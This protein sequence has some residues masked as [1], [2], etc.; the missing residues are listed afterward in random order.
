[1]THNGTLYLRNVLFSNV[2]TNLNYTGTGSVYLQNCTF[3]TSIY[4]MTIVTGSQGFTLLATNC[5]LANVTNLYGWHPAYYTFTGGYNGFY[6]SPVFGTGKVTNTFYPFQAIGAGSYYLTNGCNFFNAGTT[7][8]DSTLLADIRTK[9]TYPP[10]VYSN[11]TNSTVIFSPQAQRDTDTPDLGYHYDPLDY[12]FGGV[13]ASSNLTFAAGTAV[14]WFYNW[15]GESYGISMGDGA[16]A[17]FNGTVTAPC[18]FARYNTVQ[19]GCNG[20]WTSQGWLAGITGHSYVN[21]APA[22]SAS[23]TRCAMLNSEGNVF[24]DDW[25]FL[26]VN[27]VNC[28]FWSAAIDGY[29]ASENFTNCLFF[30]GGAGL[31]CNYV[32][33]N[34]SVENCTFIGGNL[35]ADHTSGSVWPVTV[36]NSAFDNTSIYMNAHGLATNGAYCDYNAFLTNANLTAVMGGH[37]VTNLISYNWQTSWLGNYYLPTNSPLINRGSTTA[38]QVG[39]YHYTTQTN[40]VKEA[41]SI[42]DIGY[43][44]VAMNASG[45]PLDS[46]QDGIP[47]YLE[48]ANGN[49]IA[50]A[51]ET[52]WGIAILVQPTNQIAVQTSNVTFSVTA[53]GVAPLT[54]QWYFNSAPVTN[55][56][57]MSLTLTNVQ[58]P[59]R[60]VYTVVIS[61]SSGSVESAPATLMVKANF[62]VATYGSDTNAGTSAA[63]FQH[64]QTAANIMVA[65]DVCYIRGGT[66]RE[67]VCPTASGTATNPII[68]QAYSNEAVT[69]S[70]C[71]II[72]N[73]LTYSNNSNIEMAATAKPITQIFV[74]GIQMQEAR[75]PNLP[76]GSP[77]LSPML[78]MEGWTNVFADP[79]GNLWATVAGA[80]RPDNYWQG[81]GIV[82]LCG[83]KNYAIYGKIVASTNSTVY[84]QNTYAIYGATWSCYSSCYL[85]AGEGYIVGAL[86]ELDT[87]GEWCLDSTATNLYLWPPNNTATNLVEGR[88]RHLGFNL[89]SRTNVEIMGLNFMA[90]TLS[91]TNAQSCLVDNCTVRYPCE[92]FGWTD[93][94]TRPWDA[95]N[96]TPPPPSVTGDSWV[97]KGI[98]MSGV[99]NTIADS[100]VAH[101]WGDCISIWGTSNT[102]QNCVIEDA[103]WSATDCAPING[104]GIGHTIK[105]CTIGLGARGIIVHRGLDNGLIVSNRL[106]DCGIMT[107]DNGFTYTYHDTGSV[108]IAYNW[109]H[110]G[111][112]GIY[113]DEASSNK[114]IHHNVIWH[115]GGGVGLNGYGTGGP[116]AL[117]NVYVYNNTLWETPVSIATGA[118]VTNI[119]IWNNVEPMGP[120]LSGSGLLVTNNLL[121]QATIY[122]NPYLGDFTP[123]PESP[124]ID[125]GIQINGLPAGA[126][127][128]L[129]AYKYDPSGNS[130]WV[131][132]ASFEAPTNFPDTVPPV[133]GN[134]RVTALTP[135][136]TRIEWSAAAGAQSYT[137]ERSLDCMV[138]NLVMSVG[139][140]TTSNVDYNLLPGTNYYYRVKSSSSVGRSVPSWPVPVITPSDGST[141]QLEAEDCDAIF[142]LS[143]LWQWYCPT[144]A[145]SYNCPGWVEFGHV[146]IGNGYRIFRTNV[147]F[148]D[149]N[150]H[151]VEVRLDSPTGGLVGTLMT[152]NNVEWVGTYFLKKAQILLSP[153]EHTTFIL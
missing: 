128:D 135:Y 123:R 147:A 4:L 127:P 71:D 106:H 141:I 42:V 83:A 37:E 98:E 40:Q 5:I 87:A 7:N 131:P 103:D 43:H 44:Y 137:V 91:L 74:N 6:K 33:A 122:Q 16:T 51:G 132:G 93:G 21:T 63:P 115:C 107:L 2:K 76:V 55:A 20:N 109:M 139:S 9:T 62:Y 118:L 121:T 88:T 77:M 52:N 65:G 31:W 96:G 45:S 97:G 82:V 30:R 81:A 114:K 15:S 102:V 1:M 152:T 46:N 136:S 50:D 58:P 64:I 19:E 120:S 151:R 112:G 34:L 38:D 56:T 84:V 124:T 66:Y 70:G 125:A 57:N 95:I 36:V 153:M 149:T 110:D 53:A 148:N 8:I 138:W 117:S 12:C 28:E 134:V 79:N 133:P 101:S 26:N 17:S 129:G 48:D 61:N 90:C 41:N 142:G 11:V 47:D 24:R 59:D 60:G 14:G 144:I 13:L 140:G 75:Y 111:N 80:N 32:P 25:I 3:D 78:S 29:Y 89:G 100:Y 126:A 143:I 35:I 108:E 54:Y 68:F 72:T 92:F 119:I 39:L 69:I 116:P 150:S 130:Y 85:G 10:V 99:G 23:F 146:P 145:Y 67:T 104:T 105:Q 22:I 18:V 27:A 73:W 49:G 94:C 86:G 113:I